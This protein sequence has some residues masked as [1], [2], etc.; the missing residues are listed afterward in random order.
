MKKHKLP[1]YLN[2]HPK[3][4]FEKIQYTFMVKQQTRNRRE[5]PQP[6]QELCEKWGFV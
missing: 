1:D 6:D 4:P 2:G 3:K 5:L